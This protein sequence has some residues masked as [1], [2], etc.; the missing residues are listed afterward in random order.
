LRLE[1]NLEPATTYGQPSSSL[2]HLEE[3]FINITI[4]TVE[5][6]TSNMGPAMEEYKRRLDIGT[7]GNGPD[8]VPNAVA[9]AIDSNGKCKIESFTT[10]FFNFNHRPFNLVGN[11]GVIRKKY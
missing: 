5:N 8:N 10:D 4:Q 3:N 11:K 2:L 9:I 6:I 1:F 7:S